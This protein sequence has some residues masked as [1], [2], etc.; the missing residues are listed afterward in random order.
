MWT[1]YELIKA[2]RGVQVN[3]VFRSGRLLF[4]SSDC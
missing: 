1:L 3:L 4:W 2:G